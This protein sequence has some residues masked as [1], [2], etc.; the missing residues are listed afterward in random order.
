MEKVESFRVRE[1]Y[2]SRFT[3]GTRTCCHTLCR[4]ASLGGLPM[5][6][7]SN[8]MKLPRTSGGKAGRLSWSRSYR[9]EIR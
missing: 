4:H 8:R 3:F 1:M 2:L 7:V 6:H 9:K 5:R